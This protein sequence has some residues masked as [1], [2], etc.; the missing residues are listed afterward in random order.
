MSESARDT[1]RAIKAARAIIDGRDPQKDM[2]SIMVTL[3]HLVAAVLLM[4]MK[5]PRK[6]AGMLNEGLLQGVEDR[7]ARFAALKGGEE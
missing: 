5:D 6:A 4:T 7:L 3:E 1:Q 2:S